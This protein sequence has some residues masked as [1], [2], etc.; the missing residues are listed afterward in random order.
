MGRRSNVSLL[1]EPIREVAERLLREGRTVD[2]ITDTLKTLGAEVSRSGVG[3]WKVGAEKALKRFRDVQALG[4]TWAKSLKDDPEGK[5]GRLLI[6]IGKANVLDNMLQAADGEDGQPAPMETKDL[7]F[8]SMAA[9]NFESA[10]KINADRE[11]K[12]RAEVAREIKE[13][14]GNAVEQLGKSQGLS[15]DVVAQLRAAVIGVSS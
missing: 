10:G 2:E 11:F 14:A 15:K 12:I 8:L 3:R 6:E 5:V 7:F 13:K 1:P 9:K 4:A